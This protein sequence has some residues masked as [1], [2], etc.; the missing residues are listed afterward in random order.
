MTEEV[1]EDLKENQINNIII[2]MK[3]SVDKFCS[4]LNTAREN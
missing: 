2:K 1:I 3:K 4:S